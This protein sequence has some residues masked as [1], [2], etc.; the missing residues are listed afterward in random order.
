MRRF[1]LPLS[2]ILLAVLGFI[3]FVGMIEL[4][5]RRISGGHQ[6][7]FAV[8]EALRTN[9]YIVGRVGSPVTSVTKNDGPEHAVLAARGHRYGFYS[10]TAS[11]RST[12]SEFK[13]FW[14]QLPGSNVQVYAIY[15]T[16][17]WADDVLVWGTNRPDLY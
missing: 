12:N 3:A 11:G 15:R 6:T 5:G 17:L 14:D 9:S 1:T 8:S 7:F 10:V 4:L 13:I 2:L 16:K